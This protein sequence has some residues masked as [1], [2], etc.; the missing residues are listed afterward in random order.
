M[1]VYD[2]TFLQEFS[3]NF[4]VEASD[5]VENGGFCCSLKSS[6]TQ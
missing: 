5:L 1:F 3:S 4:E 6:T 2:P